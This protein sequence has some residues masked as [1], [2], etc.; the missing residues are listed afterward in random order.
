MHACP[1][2]A[3]VRHL[4]RCSIMPPSPSR[5]L[6][7]L[8]EDGAGPFAAHDELKEMVKALHEAGIEVIVDV[9][10]NHTAEGDCVWVRRGM[11]KALCIV[12]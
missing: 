9:V 8:P 11:C 7:C 6:T 4:P 12:L 2:Q 10:Y 3:L 5:T 1:S